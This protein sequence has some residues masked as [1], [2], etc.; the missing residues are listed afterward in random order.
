MLDPWASSGATYCS[1]CHRSSTP[2]DPEG[3]HGSNVEHLLVETIVS[4][5]S[6]GTPLCYV[7]HKDSVYWSITAVGLSRLD[8]HPSD[9]GQHQVAQGCFACHMWEY[10]STAGLGVQ[11]TDWAGGTPP[12]GIFIH[13]QNKKWVYNEEDGS[14]GTQ[15]L[16]DAFLNGYLE[17]INFDVTPNNQC[18][19][20][21]CKAHSPQTY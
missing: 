21:T 12:A 8:K 13:G 6:V 10:S 3:P 18:W 1:D 14:S 19:T 20:A 17:N 4:N 5:N 2:T 16:N 7:C 15:D 9:Q 11:T